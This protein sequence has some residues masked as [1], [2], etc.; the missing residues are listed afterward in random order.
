[1][2]TVAIVNQM[3]SSGKTTTAIELAVGYATAFPDKKVL[4]VDLDHQAV[5][6]DWLL[7][8]A[9]PS[10]SEKPTIYDALLKGTAAS[11][12]ARRLK[13][14][15]DTGSPSSIDFLPSH[16]NMALAETELAS[17][18]NRYGRLRQ[19][20][21]TDKRLVG[22]YDLIIIDCPSSL[23]ILTMNALF[24][25]TDVLIPV[26]PSVLPLPRLAVLEKRIEQVGQHGNPDLS[27]LGY[28]P[29]RIAEAPIPQRT[30]AVL[31]DTYGD[32][33]L[34]AIPWR[35]MAEMPPPV[36]PIKEAYRSLAK[37]LNL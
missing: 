12:A 21:E 34:P 28:L 4:L 25:A 7:G 37:E 10:Q 32:L 1:M 19:A 29:V 3:G 13:F 31:R 35:N 20:L 11:R 26:P 14:D 24:Y 33:V 15:T 22:R 8:V 5:A 23:G 17:E 6:T 16:L 18:G 9:V 30:E 27:I 2:K 36:D